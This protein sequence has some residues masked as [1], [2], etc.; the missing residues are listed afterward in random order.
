MTQAQ[1]TSTRPATPPPGSAVRAA[2][3]LSWEEVPSGPFHQAAPSSCPWLTA[4][5][6]PTRS[7][8]W[9]L[10]WSPGT[11]W[12]PL[13]CPGAEPELRPPARPTS[14][15]LGLNPSLREGKEGSTA[16]NRPWQE[17]PEHR[18]EGPAEAPARL[19]ARRAESPSMWA[20]VA[21][22]AGEA[23]GAA[24]QTPESIPRAGVRAQQSTPLFSRRG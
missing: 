14:W 22:Q 2:G 3:S 6:Q 7:V 21:P 1:R 17:P 24:P 16:E 12:G 20:G 8:Y 15:S 23:P 5:P 11:G 4:G 18:R 13:Q 19:Q 10:P 9:S